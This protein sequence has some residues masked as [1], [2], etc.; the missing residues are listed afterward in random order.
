MMMEL[1]RNIFA[2]RTESGHYRIFTDNEEIQVFVKINT[3][4]NLKTSARLL[5]NIARQLNNL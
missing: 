1:Y 2:E 5:R 3:S 4:M